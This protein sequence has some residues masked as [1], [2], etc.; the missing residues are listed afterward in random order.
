MGQPGKPQSQGTGMI[1]YAN[2]C[3]FGLPVGDPK[4]SYNIQIAKKLD[5]DLVSRH[6]GGV[7]NRRIIRTSIR[8][9][10]TLRKKENKIVALIGLS[11][12]FRT[13]LWQMDLPAVDND[14][15][16][17]SIN[18]NIDRVIE[19]KSFYSGD[20]ED[21]Y[22]NTNVLT[23]DWY[24]QWLI[25]QNKEALLTE[26][27][28]DLV[29][30]S[31]FCKNENISY[32]VWNN[33]DLWPGH[34]EVNKEDI[35]IKDLV[36]YALNHCNIIDPW[37]FAFLPWALSQGFQPIDKE[38]YGEYGHPGPQAHS[39]LADFLMDNIEQRKIL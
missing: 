22:K 9:L 32:L 35:F 18:M 19:S 33:A 26:L 27:L 39:K 24:K 2:G 31:N 4:T 12:F 3:S 16:F 11:F 5:A 13:E 14:G 29:M 38:L 30:F 23:R 34:P 37:S 10:I 20:I 36:E 15:H 28:A 7:C 17:H 8:D 25:W 21:A 6:R 1:V